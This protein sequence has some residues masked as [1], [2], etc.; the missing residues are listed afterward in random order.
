[1]KYGPAGRPEQ[2]DTTRL[3]QTAQ[4][5]RRL[6]F[7]GLSP[8]SQIKELCA[9]IVRKGIKGRPWSFSNQH[10]GIDAV[11]IAA[12]PALEVA[13]RQSDEPRSRQPVMLADVG[14]PQRLL[15]Y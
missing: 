2:R 12:R 3:A 9:F 11:R 14:P 7:V 15:T 4:L 10:T 13:R 8:F 1:M 5:G 6:E